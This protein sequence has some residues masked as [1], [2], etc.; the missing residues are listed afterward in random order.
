MAT[1]DTCVYKTKMV[2]AAL[3]EL[4]DAVAAVNSMSA[5]VKLHINPDCSIEI[6][7]ATQTYDAAIWTEL[8]VSAMSAEPPPFLTDTTD[9]KREGLTLDIPSVRLRAFLL[10][11]RHSLKKDSQEV[12]LVVSFSDTFGYT[13][14]VNDPQREVESYGAMESAEITVDSTLHVEGTRFTYGPCVAHFWADVRIG[15]CSTRY[16][17]QIR[18]YTRTL[19]KAL[20]SIVSDES[21]EVALSLP[22]ARSEVDVTMREAGMHPPHRPKYRM[23]KPV[24]EARFLHYL[25]MHTVRPGADNKGH[26]HM[27]LVA[28]VAAST[29]VPNNTHG[30]SCI[31]ETSIFKPST[32]R[33]YVVPLARLGLEITLGFSTMKGVPITNGKRIMQAHVHGMAGSRASLVVMPSGMILPDR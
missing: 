5:T 6:H 23:A 31:L 17:A 13:F 19:I 2:R 8:P 15:K 16:T 1:D 3:I 32:V 22:S 11:G 4:L 9:Y 21:N 26:K 29:T 28:P 24:C 25:Q 33:H 12:E 27:V 7:Y 30:R 20:A 14:S 10:K 18:L